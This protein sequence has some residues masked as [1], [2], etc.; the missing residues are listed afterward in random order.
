[1]YLLTESALKGWVSPTSGPDLRT[2]V[3]S[4][5]SASFPLVMLFQMDS[6]SNPSSAI[7]ERK[8]HRQVAMVFEPQFFICTVGER[9]PA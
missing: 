3:R 1:M 8:G 2:R 9:S 6:G 4:Q 5:P 7:Y